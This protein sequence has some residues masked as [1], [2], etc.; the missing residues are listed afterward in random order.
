MYSFFHPCFANWTKYSE[1]RLHG[2]GET[3]LH[4]IKKTWTPKFKDVGR[5]WK[6]DQGQVT[7]AWLI[8]TK[9]TNLNFSV[10]DCQVL[11]TLHP[12][13]MNVYIN[14]LSTLHPL[15]MNVHISQFCLPFIPWSWMSMHFQQYF[16]YIVAVSFI[17]GVNQITRRKPPTC[18][19]SLTNFIT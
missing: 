6:Q 9:R 15:I 14:V 10:L 1:L 13:I 19:K 5:P 2:N 16:S 11:S 7:N 8:Y 17:G 3:D 12:L 4:V 18:C